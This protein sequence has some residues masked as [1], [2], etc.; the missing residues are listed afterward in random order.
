MFYLGYT[1]F[2]VAAVLM[3]PTL[4]MWLSRLLGPCLLRLRPVEG[5]LARDSLLQA[6]RRISATLA[7]LMLSTGLVVSLSG[8][9]RGVYT[10]VVDW[11]DSFLNA[12]LLV[13]ASENGTNR[14]FHFPGAMTPALAS[15]PGVAD[16]QRIR[17]NQV[18]VK[19]AA[20][21]LVAT[22]MAKAAV[23][24][25]NRVVAGDLTRMYRLAAKG[26]GVII[27]ENCGLLQKIGM[28]DVVDLPSPS[29]MVRLPVVG[30][31]T[32][33][34]NQS[35]SMFI[36]YAAVYLPYWRDPTVDIYKVYAQNG[37]SADD[38]K[39]GV[40][41]R[42]SKQRRLFV[43][44]NREVKARV[45]SN[46]RKWLGLS[47]IQIAVAVLVAVLGI[48]NTLLV[49][50]TDRRRELAMMRAVGAAR[51]SIRL[52]VWMEAAAI[53][54]IGVVLGIAFGAI[55]LFYELEVVRRDYA[56][57]TLHYSFPAYVVVALSAVII[58]AAV[59]A[60]LAASEMAVRKSLVEALEYE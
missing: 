60:S 4:G 30:I 55:D 23:R 44:V 32:D 27:S 56:G 52:S 6:P 49:S 10:S 43:G 17:S 5:A 51:S 20:I 16:I 38:L 24:G 53:A 36:D 26:E 28:G 22:D 33:Y 57:V 8:F 3:T 25:G 41:T 59:L 12:D 7:A 39:Q 1:S 37:V 54:L 15:L 46:T 34:L 35:G 19:G 42:F 45:M 29:G 13:L 58:G 48:A 21:L 50:V 14:S 9:S 18:V 47:Y 31:V 40:Q 2:V 11:V